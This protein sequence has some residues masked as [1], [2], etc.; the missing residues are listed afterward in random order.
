MQPAPQQQQ[1][2]IIQLTEEEWKINTTKTEDYRRRFLG[3]IRARIPNINQNLLAQRESVFYN[4]SNTK[5]NL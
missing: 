4:E 5:V 2:Q 3:S 1:Q